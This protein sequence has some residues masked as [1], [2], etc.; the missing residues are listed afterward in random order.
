M[1]LRLANMDDLPQLKSVYKKIIHSMD[2]NKIQIWDD[3]YPCEFFC[4]DIEK[5]CFYVLEK[6]QEILSAFALCSSHTGAKCV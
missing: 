6:N 2:K 3:I 4:N 5:N 1:H